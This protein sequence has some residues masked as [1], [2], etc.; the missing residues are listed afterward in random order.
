[1]IKIWV[2]LNIEY[3]RLDRQCL[4]GLKM[5]EPVCTEQ[6]PVVAVKVIT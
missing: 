2:A 3:K 4:K 5:K 6:R 1:M